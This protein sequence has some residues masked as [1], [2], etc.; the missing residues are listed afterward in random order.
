MCNQCLKELL[1][2]SPMQRSVS[3]SNERMLMLMLILMLIAA[4]HLFSCAAFISLTSFAS[5][6]N[7]LMTA[8]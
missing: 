8:S 6:S 7:M 3:Q 4:H 1:P 2:N 5:I